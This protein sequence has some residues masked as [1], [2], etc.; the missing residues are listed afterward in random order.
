MSFPCTDAEDE[1]ICGDAVT[2]AE[3]ACKGMD[4]ASYAMVGQ[5]VQGTTSDAKGSSAKVAHEGTAAIS[6]TLSAAA[7][8]RCMSCEKAMNHCI[9]EAC[10]KRRCGTDKDTGGGDRLCAPTDSAVEEKDNPPS[11]GGEQIRKE[12][13]KCRRVF[14]AKEKKCKELQ[15]FRDQACLQAG[16]SGAQ[17]LKS[18]LAA[19]ALGDCPEG[20]ENCIEKPEEKGAGKE[21]IKPPPMP[22]LAGAPEFGLQNTWGDKTAD[23]SGQ[24]TMLPPDDG[25]GQVAGNEESKEENGKESGKGKS[26]EDSQSGSLGSLAGLGRGLGGS[27]DSQA[28]DYGKRP[29]GLGRGSGSGLMAGNASEEEYYEDDGEEYPRSIG[30]RGGFGGSGDGGYPRS[31]SPSN[32]R[33]GGKRGFGSSALSGNRKLAGK[34]KKDTFGKGKAGGDTI[35]VRMSRF[36]NKVCYGE[37]KCR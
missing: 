37:M 14:K 28:F 3:Q 21:D 30:S 8:K 18:L 29:S 36:I 20:A 10:H 31:S 12:R 22:G 34:A 2:E 19:K 27:T 33:Y 5:A 15:T 11:D 35:F 17:A 7:L 4:M 16:L 26:G 32:S 13:Q 6:G 9:E 23:P 25:A 24:E 1:E